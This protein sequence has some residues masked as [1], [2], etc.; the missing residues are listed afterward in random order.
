MRVRDAPLQSCNA[1][2]YASYDWVTEHQGELVEKRVAAAQQMFDKHAAEQSAKA[3]AAD[4]DR[5]GSGQG[6]MVSRR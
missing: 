3:S 2:R 1:N 5:P 4:I 6:S